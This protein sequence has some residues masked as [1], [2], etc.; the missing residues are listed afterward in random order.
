MLKYFGVQGLHHFG[1]HFFGAR[2]ALF[3]FF[4]FTFL[5]VA[6]LFPHVVASEVSLVQARVFDVLIL[7][8]IHA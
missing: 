6:C 1:F 3:K 8:P 7:R 5:H 4:Y 2:L